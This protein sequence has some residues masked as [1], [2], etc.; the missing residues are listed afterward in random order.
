MLLRFGYVAM[1]VILEDCSPSRTVTFKTYES[2]RKKD[3]GAALNKLRR[4]AREN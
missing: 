4:T 3:P 2:L 1:S